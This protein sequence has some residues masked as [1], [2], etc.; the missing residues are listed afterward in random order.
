MFM[1]S[2]I[3]QWREW[4]HD[5]SVEWSLVEWP[6]H[7]GLQRLVRDLN[8]IYRAEPSLHEVDF[9][10][11]GFQWIDCNDAD[12]S[13]VS[14]IRRARDPHDLTVMVLNFTPVVRRAYRVGVPEAGRY[15]EILNTDADIY[16]GSNVGNMGGVEAEDA[17][18]HG[19]PHSLSLVLPPL[20][21]A[22]FKPERA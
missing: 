9:E 12:S 17:P 13:V 2:E 6:M 18:S 11:A 14:L 3:G 4:D 22:I 10:P 1:G 5:G 7:A 15:R 19:H 21:C 8:T 16:G 20:A